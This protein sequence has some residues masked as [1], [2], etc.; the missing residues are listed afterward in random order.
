MMD[1]LRINDWPEFKEGVHWLTTAAFGWQGET[2]YQVNVAAFT[3]KGDV[4]RS[5]TIFLWSHDI[6]ATHFVLSFVVLTQKFL[7]G[8][9]KAEKFKL[10]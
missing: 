7:Q 5:S 2:V 3:S 8:V 6:P 10:W 9:S 4:D 1:L